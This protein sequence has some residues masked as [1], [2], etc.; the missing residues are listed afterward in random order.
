MVKGVYRLYNTYIM[1]RKSLGVIRGHW[2]PKGDFDPKKIDKKTPKTQKRILS[3]IEKYCSKWAKNLGNR[4]I[5]PRPFDWYPFV[6]PSKNFRGAPPPGVTKEGGGD[7]TIYIFIYIKFRVMLERASY[8]VKQQYNQH[9]IKNIIN[10][11]HFNLIAIT[12]LDWPNRQNYW[13]R[14]SRARIV[15]IYKLNHLS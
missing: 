7:F 2:R 11:F 12:I 1:L 14:E 4:Q 6:P 15:E 10:S 9:S 13:L 5:S 8:E 3:Q